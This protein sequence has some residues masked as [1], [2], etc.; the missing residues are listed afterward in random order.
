[1]ISDVKGLMPIFG[2]PLIAYSPNHSENALTDRK[3]WKHAIV[4]EGSAIKDLSQNETKIIS[5]AQLKL[6]LTEKMDRAIKK[7]VP[8]H[9]LYNKTNAFS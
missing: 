6:E 8:V 9:K 3:V 1:M 5:T 4:S 2:Y 7:G